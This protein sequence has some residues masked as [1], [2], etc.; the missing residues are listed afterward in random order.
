VLPLEELLPHVT[1]VAGTI[2]G[3]AP[4]AVRLGLG[5]ALD[6]HHRPP[7]SHQIHE[8]IQCLCF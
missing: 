4:I 6:A 8:E 7:S 5:R 1:K 2:A 3:R